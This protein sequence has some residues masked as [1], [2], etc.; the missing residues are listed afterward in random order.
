M[1]PIAWKEFTSLFKSIKSILVI[2][3]MIGISSGI[4]KLLS[5]FGDQITNEMGI[6]ETPFSAG[7]LLTVL[8]ASP[9]FIFTLSHNIINEE[10]KSRTIRFLA[11]KTNRNNI[12]IGKFLGALFFWALC[13]L[14]TTILLIWYSN[15]F[16]LIEW[17]QCLVFISYYLALATLISVL[18]DNTILTNFLGIAISL[19]MTVL[20]LWSLNSDKFILKLYSYLTPYFYYFKDDKIISFSVLIFTIIFLLISLLVFKKRDL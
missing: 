16:Y 6:N 10:I 18:I 9:L 15:Q 19:V 8:L 20:G 11:T 17:L 13:L 4:A 3:I 12:I 7:L 2:I 14:I 1:F 5:I